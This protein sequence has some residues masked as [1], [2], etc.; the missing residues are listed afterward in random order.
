MKRFIA[1]V[2]FA[3][4]TV[5][6]FAGTFEQTELDR[7]LPQ[8]LESA[9][10]GASAERAQRNVPYEQ[11]QLDRALPSVQAG[12][13]GMHASVRDTIDYNFIAPAQ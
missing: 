11:N 9:S 8:G 4:L 6:A 10:A 13:R 3:A 5:P 1:A 12:T 7:A 2:S